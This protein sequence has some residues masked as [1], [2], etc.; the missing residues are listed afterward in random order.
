MNKDYLEYEDEMDSMDD[1]D[2][3]ISK[4][5]DPDLSDQ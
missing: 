2:W 5:F 4:Q 3:E 1:Y